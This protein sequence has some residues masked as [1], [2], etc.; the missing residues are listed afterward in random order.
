MTGLITKDKTFTKK[1]V[2]PFLT[3]LRE[4]VLGNTK[5]T[6]DT[7][8]SCLTLLHLLGENIKD[9]D[10]LV[11][12]LT[13]YKYS[14]I[15]IEELIEEDGIYSI[16]HSDL[17]DSVSQAKINPLQLLI[18]FH[19]I[20]RINNTDNNHKAICIGNDI[21]RCP[22]I[23]KLNMKYFNLYL[24]EGKPRKV[25][26]NIKNRLIKYYMRIRNIQVKSYEPE[27]LQDYLKIDRHYLINLFI[28]SV[29]GF[30]EYKEKYLKKHTD[31]QDISDEVLKKKI[32]IQINNITNEDAVE[33]TRTHLSEQDLLSDRY[34]NYLKQYLGDG[35]SRQSHRFNISNSIFRKYIYDDR[36]KQYLTQEIDIS[37]TV[38]WLMLQF[39]KILGMEDTDDSIRFD[40][41]IKSGKLY[42]IIGGRINLDRKVVKNSMWNIIFGNS[43]KVFNSNFQEITG[44]PVNLK[45]EN[46][47]NIWNELNKEYPDVFKFFKKVRCSKGAV[48]KNPETLKF[49]NSE[50]ANILFKFEAD[51]MVDK[52]SKRL[53]DL[54][55]V[56][57]VCHD[58]I[59]AKDNESDKETI[60]RIIKE[61]FINKFGDAPTI[62]IK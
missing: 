55:I 37:A 32:Q 11:E 13:K 14:Q 44:A 18:D 51:I 42:D 38:P 15:E 20:K 33:I 7:I 50:F 59:C 30:Y 36:D 53:T 8:D 46:I 61:E 4:N 3:N 54:N 2:L 24:Y 34:Q 19:I 48:K 47:K 35:V 1:N 60:Q 45:M 27:C 43:Y 21:K 10:D 56:H 49:S 29:K 9:N 25:N 40:T 28:K 31:K 41:D 16:I 26:I 57:Y 23:Y 22:N 39:F 5:C 58:A 62:S 12:L 52:V 6:L 17:I